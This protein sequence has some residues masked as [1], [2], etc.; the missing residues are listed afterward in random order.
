MEDTYRRV[1]IGN[2]LIKLFTEN[3]DYSIAQLLHTIMRTKNIRTGYKNSYFMNDNDFLV[4]LEAT[5]KEFKQAD[6]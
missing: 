1:S 5:I 3:S 6:E 2:K 4:A